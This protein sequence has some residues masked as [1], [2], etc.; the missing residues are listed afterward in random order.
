MRTVSVLG[1]CVGVLVGP[2]ERLTSQQPS[3]PAV[4]ATRASGP[5]ADSLRA[6][7]FRI[8]TLLRAR[9]VAASLALYGDTTHF[10]HVENGVVIPWSQLSAMMRAYFATVTSN[11]VRIVGEPGVTVIDANTGVLYVTHRFD[12]VG[13]RAA[14]DGV[15]T[16]VVRRYGNSWKIVH[17]HSSDRPSADSARSRP[18]RE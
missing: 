14:H 3:M 11:P 6:F 7:A 17:S 2:A 9:D 13:D 1:L 10:V 16:G 12:A 4:G 18:P 5:Q 15:W 8:V